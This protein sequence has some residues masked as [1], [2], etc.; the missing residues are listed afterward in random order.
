MTT[1]K[2]GIIGCGNI[3]N[4]YFNAAKQFSILEVAACADIDIERARAKA[5]EHGIMR[6]LTPEQLLADPDVE[7]VIN[8]TIPKAHYAVC[9]AALEAGKHVH[10]EK[11]LAITREE[12]DDLVRIAAEKNL[13]LGAAPDTFLGGAHQTCR[14]LIDDGALG[15]PIGCSA[16]MLG[17]GH[18]SW[19]PDPEFYYKLGGGP[20]FDMGPYYLTALVNMMGP[21]ERVTGS[22]RVTFPHRTITSQPKAGETIDVDVPTHIAGIMDFANGAVGTITTSFDVWAHNLPNIEVYG[23]LGS[24]HVPDPNGFGGTVRIKRHDQ[25]D[26]EEVVL[27]HGFT[28]NC[29]GVGVAD[30]AQAIRDGRPHRA[31]GTLGNHV[32][33]AMHC[34]H[35]ASM[36]SKHYMMRTTVERPAALPVGLSE[37]S[38]D[39][40]S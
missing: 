9:R 36:A 5:A 26:W 17:H 16:F 37:D 21:I 24:L 18:E 32:L 31:S 33:E 19:H 22:A 39:S 15:E 35:D 28:G 34:F 11:P 2:I 3:S 14:K 27:T 7:I 30:M 1:T 23:T 4:A 38:L 12:G 29:R 25:P 13:R 8:L 6:A 40:I 10:V 20:M